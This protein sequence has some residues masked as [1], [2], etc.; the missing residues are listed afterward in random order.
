MRASI[1]SPTRNVD[2]TA[3]KA[4]RL[5][6]AEGLIRQQAPPGPSPALIRGAPKQLV[7]VS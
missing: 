3:D 4:T 7:L 1:L 2:A 5:A 6:D